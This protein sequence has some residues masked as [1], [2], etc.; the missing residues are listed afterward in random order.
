MHRVCISIHVHAE[1]VR[2]HNTL[3]SLRSHTTSTTQLLLTYRKYKATHPA[4]LR[5]PPAA[6]ERQRLVSSVGSQ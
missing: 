2:L 5:T 4:P 6:P 3:A 1:P